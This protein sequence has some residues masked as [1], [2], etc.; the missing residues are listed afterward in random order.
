MDDRTPPG[1]DNAPQNRSAP[2]APRTDDSSRNGRETTDEEKRASPNRPV[3]SSKP[4]LTE[5]ERRERWPID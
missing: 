2:T 1:R 3:S 5:R 4:A